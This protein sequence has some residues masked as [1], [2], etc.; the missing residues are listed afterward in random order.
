MSGWT[1]A[2][3]NQLLLLKSAGLSY[4]EIA[5]KLPGR[6]KY[7]AKG[8]YLELM[9][10]YKEGIEPVYGTKRPCMCCQRPFISEG[11]HNRLCGY[12]KRQTNL[13]YVT[14]SYGHF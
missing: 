8:R 13:D 7:A 10:K 5:E 6:S 4:P 3:D 9:R 11:K 14:P 2:E 1:P 12:C